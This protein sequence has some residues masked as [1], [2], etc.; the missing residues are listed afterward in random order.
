MVFAENEFGMKAHVSPSI[1]APEEVLFQCVFCAKT[2]IG[3]ETEALLNK[4]IVDAHFY[5]KFEKGLRKRAPF[6]CPFSYCRF[7]GRSVQELVY[8]YAGPDHHVFQKV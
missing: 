7:N 2:H 1:L 3:F 8:H 6:L 4:H 5:S